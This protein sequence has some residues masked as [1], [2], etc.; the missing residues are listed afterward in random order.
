MTREE[1]LRPPTWFRADL[2]RIWEALAPRLEKRGLLAAS[3]RTTLELL[4][5]AL[6]GYRKALDDA[7]AAKGED[8]RLLRQVAGHERAHARELA[9]EFL[10]V[11]VEDVGR[12]FACRRPD[13][14]LEDLLNPHA[15][16][17]FVEPLERPD[18]PPPR[19]IH[20]RKETPPMPTA[21]AAPSPEAA[22][23]L[24]R[25]DDEEGRS[26]AQ[27][28]APG[29]PDPRLGPWTEKRVTIL[30]ALREEVEAAARKGLGAVALGE[31]LDAVAARIPVLSPPTEFDPFRDRRAQ[32][33]AH[34]KATGADVSGNL[35]A[36]RAAVVV[37]AARELER[38]LG[39]TREDLL[40]A[41]DASARSRLRARV[42]TL[43]GALSRLRAIDLAL[44]HA[45]AAP[46]VAEI[47]G[48]LSPREEPSAPPQAP[49]VKPA[50]AS[51]VS[52]GK[53]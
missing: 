21:T 39:W 33:L 29:D 51:R 14:F 42:E 48:A 34:A 44:G 12:P 53:R 36:L 22:Q 5:I 50:A 38:D 52:R 6:R 8:A 30:R 18:P 37:E 17:P 16:L 47:R 13:P 1:L 31:V 23:L 4:C 32:L 45:E 2:R 25:L 24:R 19:R 40:R 20:R 27:I 28:T 26:T 43:E 15:D 41:P 9:A 35:A 10:L 46:L 3:D 49:A 11:A 7:A